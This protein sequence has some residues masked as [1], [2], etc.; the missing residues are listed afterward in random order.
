MTVPVTESADLV[1]LNGTL[2][3]VDD[4]R[5]SAISNAAMYGK[6]VFTTIAVAEGKPVLWDKHLQRLSDHSSRLGIRF[7]DGSPILDALRQLLAANGLTRGRARVT[8][9]DASPGRLWSSDPRAETFFLITAAAPRELPASLKISLSRFAVNSRSPM[10]GIKSCNYLENLLVLEDAN[11]RGFNETIRL[12]E[13]GEITSAAMANIFWI[14]NGTIF[15]PAPETGCLAGTTREFVLENFEVNEVCSGIDELENADNI[16]LT[17]AGI[18]IRRAFAGMD[19][20][21][22]V[23]ILDEIIAVYRQLEAGFR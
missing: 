13:R 5:L 20:E 6:G 19:R 2:K 10:A 21:A 18:G 17:S 11:N 14:T 3:A 9:F 4:A 22:P 16:F 7:D 1:S 8:L 23:P 12:N 15:T